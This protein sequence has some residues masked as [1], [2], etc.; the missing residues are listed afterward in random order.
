[1]TAE[2]QQKYFGSEYF[3][4]KRARQKLILSIKFYIFRSKLLFLQT[5]FILNYANNE[6]TDHFKTHQKGF[7][8]LLPNSI[9]T[10]INYHHII[11]YY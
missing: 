11:I 7:S 3:T 1:M 2:Y 5:A 9:S 10:R 8:L 6:Q 4:H